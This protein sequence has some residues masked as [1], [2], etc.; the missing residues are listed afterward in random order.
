MVGAA[1]VLI[2]LAWWIG[3]AGALTVFRIIY[4]NK[5]GIE[6]FRVFAS[7]GLHASNNPATIKALTEGGQGLSSELVARLERMLPATDTVGFLVVRGKQVLFERYHDGWTRSSL[8]QSFSMGKS[9]VSML[10]GAAIDDGYIHS[11]NDP[12]TGY[13]PEL[14]KGGFSDVTIEDLLQMRSG[15]NYVEDENP[16]GV[17]ARFTYTPDVESEVLDLRVEHGGHPWSYKSGDT[18][19]L[20]LVLDRALTPKTVTD[21]TQ[22]KLWS[23]LRMESSGLW[24]I[25]RPGGLEKTWSCMAAT[26]R[27]Y[28]KL[29]RLYLMRGRFRGERIIPASWVQRSVEQGF[30]GESVLNEHHKMMGVWSY[31]YHWWLVSAE[32]RD[33]MA[34]GHDGQF[35]YVNP[36]T[37]SVIV[38]L[39]KGQGDLMQADW[40]KLFQEVSRSL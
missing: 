13:I 4:Y 36:T 18:A 25:D 32:D 21:Y 6:D 17:H 20:T 37:N 34:A 2:G 39:G 14:A 15:S 23:P 22:E 30:T 19:I 35:V 40:I 29:G 5:T 1:S 24:M 31:N 33:Y 27:D 10:I 8:S 11:V 38:R 26:A 9:F 12:V 3:A 7:R 16:F 28:A